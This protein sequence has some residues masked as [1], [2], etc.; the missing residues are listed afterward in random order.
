MMSQAKKPFSADDISLLISIAPII[1]LAV[2]NANHFNQTRSQTMRLTYINDVGRVLTGSLD[3]ER[4]LQ[5]IIEGVNSLLETERTSVFLIDPDTKELVLRYHTEG[6]AEIRLPAGQGIAGWVAENDKPA[7]VNDT[8][9][10]PRHLRKIAVETG[11]EANSILCVP[12][13]VERKVIGVVEVLNQTSKQQFTMEHQVRLTELAQWAGIAIQN[14][15]LYNELGQAYQKLY[16]EK[17]RRYAAEMR[18]AMASVILDMA[19]TMNNIVGAIR[20]W[21][22]SLEHKALNRPELPLAQFKREMTNMRQNAEEAIKLIKKMTDPLKKPDISPTDIHSCLADA[23]QSCFWPENVQLQQEYGQ[24]VPLVKADAE[25]LEA[26]L[27]NLL[28]NASK[29]LEERGGEVRVTTR[30][31]SDGQAEIWVA[32]NGPGIPRELQQHIFTPQFSDKEDGL[33]IGLWLTETYINQFEGTITFTSSA[34][35]GTT[36]K[37]ILQPAETELDYHLG[38]SPVSMSG[39]VNYE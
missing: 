11:Y 14:A 32:D 25:R 3:R 31:T 6:P 21:A 9:S 34:E 39:E 5:F 37:I 29:A 19:H 22:T 30:R 4:V 1:G 16:N 13:K 38:H 7:L 18:G 27:N 12:L 2:Q 28:S 20:V 24:D 17:E 23:I 8:N 35:H 10:D 36:F 26:A 15:N 33:G